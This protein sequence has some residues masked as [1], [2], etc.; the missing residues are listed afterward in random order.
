MSKDKSTTPVVSI[1]IPVVDQ[2]AMT[3]RCLQSI[4]A[5]TKLPHE[6]IWIDN[7]SKPENLGVIRRQATRPRV[8]CKLIKNKNNVGFIKATN[9][10]IRE[11]KS[12]Y[13]ILLNND[14]E[15]SWR[16][17][18][19]LLKPLMNNTKVGAVGPVTQSKIAWQEASNLNRRWKMGLPRLN[20]HTKEAYAEILSK[21]FHGKYLDVGSHPLSFFCVAMRRSIFSEIGYLCEEMSVGLGDDDEF[22]MRLRAHEYTL[23]ISLS[24]FVYHAHRTTFNALKLGVDSLRRHNLPILKRKEKEL[25]KKLGKPVS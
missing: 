12:D 22:C 21:K 18:S 14:T 5:N 23:M 3:V 19:K 8:Q 20:G 25:K 4:R 6:I 11:S 16:W 24:T 7:G 1:I 13:I 10:G 15:V 2:A 17:A 9:Q